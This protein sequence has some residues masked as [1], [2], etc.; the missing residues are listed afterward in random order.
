MRQGLLSGSAQASS[1]FVTLQPTTQRR[2]G[3]GRAV[4]LNPSHAGKTEA[5]STEALSF[6]DMAA[7]TCVHFGISLWG[8]SA[9]VHPRKA[10]RDIGRQ[11]D[12]PTADLQLLERTSAPRPG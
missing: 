7:I 11:A 5:S 4:A 12:R 1:G 6:A 9:M 8:V 10:D 2:Y 3:T